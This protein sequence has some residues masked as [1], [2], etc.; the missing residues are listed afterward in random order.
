MDVAFAYMGI[1]SPEITT[2]ADALVAQ[3]L[4]DFRRCARM[5]FHSFVDQYI[6]GRPLDSV[7]LPFGWDFRVYPYDQNHVVLEVF[8]T[9]IL[10]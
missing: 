1:G 3:F 6:I 5:E 10:V 2:Q 7:V 8:P 4:T 9:V